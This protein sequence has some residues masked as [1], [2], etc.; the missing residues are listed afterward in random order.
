M[1]TTE[2]IAVFEIST[3]KFWKTTFVLSGRIKE[4]TRSHQDVYATNKTFCLAIRGSEIGYVTQTLP[5]RRPLWF[6]P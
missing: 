6:F 4:H 2:S 1:S 3:V 5:T